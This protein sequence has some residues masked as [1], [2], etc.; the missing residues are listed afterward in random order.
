LTGGE[1]CGP[2]PVTL[3]YKYCNK[4]ADTKFVP[5]LSSSKSYIKIN[6]S[7]QFFNPLPVSSDSCREIEVDEKLNTCRDFNEINMRVQGTFQGTDDW[8]FDQEKIAIKTLKMPPTPAPKPVVDGSLCKVQVACSLKKN[9]KP[10][11]GRIIRTK[12]SCGKVQAKVLWRYC[13]KHTVA[14]F[15]PLN[16]KNKTY[17]KIRGKQL[18][19]DR[20][21]IKQGKCRSVFTIE[22]I[23][24]CLDVNKIEMRVEGTYDMELNQSCTSRKVINLITKEVS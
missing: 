11:L 5:D 21:K 15:T 13:N 16:D 23:N 8:C 2:V 6:G 10:C 22:D 18:D 1:N 7:Y 14:T 12:S 4:N 20:S 9:G 24:T 19:M 3:R 17:M